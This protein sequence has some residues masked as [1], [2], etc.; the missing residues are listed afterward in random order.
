M[1]Q[2]GRVCRC[3]TPRPLLMRSTCPVIFSS[4]RG[5]SFFS[6]G[7]T[8]SLVTKLG[9]NRVSTMIMTG[10]PN[11]PFPPEFN[12][13]LEGEFLPGAKAAVSVVT[14]GVAEADWEA[15]EGLVS[16]TC[17]EGIKVNTTNIEDK[18][19]MEVE[20]DDIFFTFVS[21]PD[22]CEG[23]NNLNLV[24]FSF[25]MMGVIKDRVSVNKEKTVQMKE[26]LAEMKEKN[27]D[28]ETFMNVVKEFQE[29]IAEN[30]PHNLFK[31]NEILIGNFRFE[32]N[33]ATSEWV[34]TEV[35]QITSLLAWPAIF[36]MRWK[37]RLGISLRTGYHFHNVLRY[38][39]TT[40][41]IVWLLLGSYLLTSGA[42]VGQV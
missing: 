10:K 32:R 3:L 12:V 8:T 5:L 36:R 2:I 37:G 29:K 39:Y 25:P 14:R 35:G 19:L 26:T 1:S 11:H 28:R 34:I 22:I 6:K 21:N 18:E 13:D 33:S 41:W 7:D 23:G 15:L 17:L 24:T 38:D 42:V 20:V 27:A 31:S 9:L 40:D 30:D 16:P 4:P